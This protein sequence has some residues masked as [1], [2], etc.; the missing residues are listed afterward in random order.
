MGEGVQNNLHV[1]QFFNLVKASGTV[2]M[3]LNTFG[4]LRTLNYQSEQKLQY[5]LVLSFETAS[6]LFKNTREPGVLF[7]VMLSPVTQSLSKKRCFGRY[8][9]SGSNL[10]KIRIF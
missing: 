4:G 1:T 2:A 3:F 7:E 9:G 5:L 10:G 8:W 6:F